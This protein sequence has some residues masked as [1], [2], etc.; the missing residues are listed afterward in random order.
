MKEVFIE[1]SLLLKR[2]ILFILSTFIL[3]GLSAQ[4]D[5]VTLSPNELW[6]K[7]MQHRLDSI[8]QLVKKQRYSVGYSIMD[9]TADSVIYRYNGQKMLKPASTQKLFV[10]TTL[11][12]NLSRDYEFRT[13]LYVDGNVAT[14]SVGRRYLKG[15][16]CIRGS[17]DPTLQ[18]VD[19]EQFAQKIQSLK[20]DSIDG[21]IIADNR[22]KLDVKKVKD[23]PK[24]FAENLYSSLVQKG[25]VFS[26]AEPF[27][28]SAEPLARGWCLA[29]I[30]TPVNKILNVMLKKSDNG[31]AECVLQNLCGMGRNGGWTYENCKEKVRRMVSQV[32]DSAQQY[33]I[34]D[35]S[36][37]S[38]SN[39]C[40]SDV[41]VDLLRYD[42]KNPDIFP[43]IYEN[44]PIAGIDGTLSKRMKTGPLYNNVRAKTGTLNDTSTLAGYFT[45]SNGH[46]MAFAVMVNNLGGLSVG[47][48]LQESICTAL[49]K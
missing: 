4:T 17:F 22:V 5:S 15:D 37:L 26:S 3:L 10:A 49:A 2:I 29:T 40:S 44:L 18:T 41:L 16:I 42:Y 24:Y 32:T 36:G 23:V 25:I 46:F 1:K 38:Y 34:E 12:N 11:L 43:S 14:D 8:T 6:V 48:S 21:R 30:A 20:I 35:G 33:I 28:S 31:Y 9:L 19:I 7:T 13:Q 45:A 27:G 39:K 47:K